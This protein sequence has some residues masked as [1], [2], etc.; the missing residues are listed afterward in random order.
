M[1]GHSFL[2]AKARD[3]NAGASAAATEHE[4]HAAQVGRKTATERSLES[5]LDT[6]SKSPPSL[7]AAPVSGEYYRTRIASSGDNSGRDIHGVGSGDFRGNQAG[8]A[9]AEGEP[10]VPNQ[11][12]DD[13]DEDNSN[14]NNSSKNG[15]ASNNNP[16]CTEEQD[17]G[18]ARG[19]RC[20]IWVDELYSSQHEFP[21]S[22]GENL[23]VLQPLSP[24][25]T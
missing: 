10:V 16:P 14:N 7:L 1:A 4:K 9:H 19:T 18:G 2:L 20:A 22:F 6:V 15:P 3:I 23:R 17:G 5:L 25:H 8:D 24:Y 21:L 11:N 13:D 12:N